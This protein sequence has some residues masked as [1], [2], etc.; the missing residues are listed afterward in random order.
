MLDLTLQWMTSLLNYTEIGEI[1]NENEQH[2]PQNRNA[3]VH[4]FMMF[5]SRHIVK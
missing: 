1:K 5:F 2:F 3:Q 4:H